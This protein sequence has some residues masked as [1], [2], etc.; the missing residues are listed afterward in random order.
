VSERP[1]TFIALGEGVYTVPEVARILRRNNVTESKVRYWLEKGLLGE[2]IRW[3]SRG[4]PHL[5]SFQQLLKVRTIQRLRDDGFSLQRITPAVR[6]LSSYLWEHLFDEEWHELTFFPAEGGR[7]G[8]MDNQRR[9]IV[10]ETGQWIMPETLHELEDYLRQTREEWERRE[11]GIKDFPRLVSNA[12]IVAG[13]PTIKGT[14]VETSFISHMARGLGVG[15]VLQLYPY[16]DREALLEATEF[17]GVR[18]LAA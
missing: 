7:I 2:P 17:E 9:A 3:G 8:V 11:V 12:G 6:K 15:R 14:R 18:P 5:L 1:T 10:V 16:V 13:S 4:R